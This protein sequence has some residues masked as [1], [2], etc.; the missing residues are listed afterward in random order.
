MDFT[1]LAALRRSNPLCPSL[2]SGRMLRDNGRVGVVKN[3][4]A[5][6]LNPI[7]AHGWPHELQNA[8]Q[9]SHLRRF[10]GLLLATDALPSISLAGMPTGSRGSQ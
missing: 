8:T 2:H 1:N 7:G 10:S 3:A 4:G 9:L 5:C 6:P